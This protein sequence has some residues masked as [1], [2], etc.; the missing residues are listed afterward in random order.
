MLHLHLKKKNNG[1]E[2]LDVGGPLCSGLTGEY[3]THCKYQKWH[4]VG[5]W[6][7]TSW[8]KRLSIYIKNYHSNPQK[9]DLSVLKITHEA[10][11]K[12]KPHP[13]PVAGVIVALQQTID[14]AAVR[15]LEQRVELL[16]A[17]QPFPVVT[18]SQ[19]TGTAAQ[20]LEYNVYV[21]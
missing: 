1:F 21:R 9:S 2:Y 7:K 11:V 5:T 19:S 10:F 13:S 18:A 20:L 15:A 14:K 3:L 8:T 16:Q 17:Q 12:I 6:T 4:I